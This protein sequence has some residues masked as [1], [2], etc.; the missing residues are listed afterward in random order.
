M[1]W[2]VVWYRGTSRAKEVFIYQKRARG[3]L[4]LSH[5]INSSSFPKEMQ[6]E[7]LEW[8]CPFGVLSCVFFLCAGV[9]VWGGGGHQDMCWNNL[10]VCLP[11]PSQ[12]RLKHSIE[13]DEKG[14][15]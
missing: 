12:G 14:Q 6:S 3:F 9:R 1:A 7:E 4:H 15:L 8:E 11:R 2:G 5:R 10:C 13:G